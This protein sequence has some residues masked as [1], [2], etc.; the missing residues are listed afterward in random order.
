MEGAISSW[1]Q[2]LSSSKDDFTVSQPACRDLDYA[3]AL[4]TSYWNTVMTKSTTYRTTSEANQ[5][6]AIKTKWA[7]VRHDYHLISGVL[8]AWHVRLFK[9][10][11]FLH[12]AQ[13]FS[14]P[15]KETTDPGRCLPSS[16]L[17]LQQLGAELKT[18]PQKQTSSTRNFDMLLHSSWC[19]WVNV[20]RG[21]SGYKGLWI[22]GGGAFSDIITVSGTASRVCAHT[23]AISTRAVV[24]YCP[25]PTSERIP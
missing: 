7:S 12:A 16:P 9:L 23:N 5:K 22:G 3:D 10:R 4:C 13:V 25:L 8:T 2:L 20:C 17:G 24:I 1:G 21:I 6:S 18:C 14:H 15:E 19:L 11:C